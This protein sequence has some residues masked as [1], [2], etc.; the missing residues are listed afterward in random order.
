MPHR[1]RFLGV[2]LASCVTLPYVAAQP[3]PAARKA[4]FWKVTSASSV[5]YLLGS[6]HLGSKDMYPLPKEIEDA[7]E[8]STALI[9]EADIRHTDMQKT[10][11]MVLAKGMYPSDDN[12]WNHVSP[13]TRKSVEEFCKKFE[14][15]GE[16]LARMKP[17]VVAVTLA[18]VPMIKNGMDPSLGIDN[19]FLEKAGKKRIV[20]IE[21][22]EWQLNLLSSFTDEQQEQ[23]LRAATE[24]GTELVSVMKRL[25]DAWTKGDADGMD[26]LVRETSRTPEAITRQLL[27]DRN[28]HMADV[29][30]QFLKGKEQA[31]LV[32]GAAHMVGKEGLVA[33]LQ[34]RGY[35]VEQVSLKK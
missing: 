6:I 23:F 1:R 19:Y 7:F 14:L 26:A 8:S 2:L 10:Q 13:A 11:T 30:E 25:Q 17:W 29:A 4:M 15:P 34:K 12:L 24:E 33:L 22:A 28:P 18:T 21:S 32:V 9:V 35:K 20:E 3:A 27:T 5:T 31:F 16:A